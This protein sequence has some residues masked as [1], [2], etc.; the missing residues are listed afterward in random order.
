MIYDTMTQWQILGRM[1]VRHLSSLMAFWS[2][3]IHFVRACLCKN[4]FIIQA[5]IIF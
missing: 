1:E 3:R 4:W 5:N 2:I